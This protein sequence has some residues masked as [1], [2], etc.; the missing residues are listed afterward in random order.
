MGFSENTWKCFA[1]YRLQRVD[2]PEQEKIIDYLARS[3][4]V[5]KITIDI[6]AGGGGA[7]I[8]QSLK[9]RPEYAT[10]DYSA[11]IEG[12]QFNEKVSIASFDNNIEISE[13]FKAWATNEMIKHISS[14]FL[15]FSEIDAEG[16]S[17]IERVARQKRTSGHMHY[18]VVSPRG[19]GESN[20]DH[21]YASYLCFIGALRTAIPT[22]KLAV[23]GRAS[24][25]YTER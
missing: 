22:A 6:G 16:V 9:S 12:I 2:Y 10:F 19:H 21:I 5:S 17:Q 3:Y 11:K 1:R 23:I 14:G 18:Y 4:N 15:V 7:G 8:M 25:H 20:D 13:S 24:A